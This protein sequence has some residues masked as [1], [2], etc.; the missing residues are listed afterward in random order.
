M[1]VRSALQD[2]A[3]FSFVLDLTVGMKRTPDGFVEQHEGD[4]R[5]HYSWL[6]TRAYRDAFGLLTYR[7][8]L[9]AF[10]PNCVVGPRSVSVGTS[11]KSSSHS[12]RAAAPP[13]WSRT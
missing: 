12:A 5:T 1:R 3:V 6:P 13:A 10:Q 9:P 4:A 8:A 7:D 2:A 11:P